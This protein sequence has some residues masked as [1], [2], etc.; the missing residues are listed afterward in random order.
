[1]K[2]GDMF[3]LADWRPKYRAIYTGEFRAP[4]KGEWFLSGAIVEAY[5]AL[6][7]KMTT[8]YH[9]AALVKVVP[10]MTYR[11]VRKDVKL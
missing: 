2:R 5:R 1:M 7:D 8:K 10:V 9:I 3:P 11:I 4:R 6:T